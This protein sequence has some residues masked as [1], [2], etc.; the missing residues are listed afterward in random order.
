MKT[1]PFARIQV[2]I[3]DDVREKSMAF[4]DQLFTARIGEM[5]SG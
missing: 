3:L 2:E 5:F 4:D 1:S